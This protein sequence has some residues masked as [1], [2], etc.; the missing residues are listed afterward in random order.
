[1][2]HHIP[3]HHILDTGI[4][5]TTRNNE[6]MSTTYT[7][8]ASF[9]QVINE[10]ISHMVYHV[11]NGKCTL[12]YT[13]E[14]SILLENPIK[15]ENHQYDWIDKVTFNPETRKLEYIC[16]SIDAQLI[17]SIPVNTQS[18]LLLTKVHNQIIQET[19]K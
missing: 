12:V 3:V 8:Q 14:K 11:H 10:I 18:V 6:I 15:F 5:S 19:S 9:I 2:I 7:Q 16:S 13:F 1:M 4:T 17:Q